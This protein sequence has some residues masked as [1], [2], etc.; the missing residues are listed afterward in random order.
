MPLSLGDKLGPYEIIDL[1]GKGGMGEVYRAHDDRLRR[2]VAIKVSNAHFTERFT[3]EART[4]AA[5]NHTNIAHL[6]D[7]GPNYLVMELVEGEDLKG[8][9]TFDD[10]LPIIQQLIDGIEAAHEKGIIHR[11]L[12]PANIKI[13]PEG[14]VK[15][16]DFGLAKA[17][18]TSQ[19]MEMDPGNSPTLTMGATAVGTILGTAAYM[20]PEQAK[21]KTADKRSDV[22]SFGVVV[23]E[24]LTGKHLFQGE[25][26]VE[27][28]GGVLNKEP[29]FSAAPA[30]LHRLLQWCLQKDRKKRLAAISDARGLLDEETAPVAV[31][32]AAGR[33]WLW[34]AVTAGLAVATGVALWAP[35]RSGSSAPQQQL[36]VTIHPAP[37]KPTDLTYLSPD[38]TRMLIRNGPTSAHEMLTLA[39]GELRTLPGTELARA[40][41]WS[42][43]SRF[44]AFFKDDKLKVIPAAGGPA[45][46]IC[47]GT[48]GGLGGSWSASGIVLLGS[49]AGPIRMVKMTNGVAGG[50]CTAVLPP[51][52]GTF[53]GYPRW[54][55]D[56]EHF[57]YT[58]RNFGD[59]S[60]QGV[61]LASLK[62]PA[63]RRILGD[64]T[65]VIYAPPAAGETAGQLLFRRGS[66]LM[67]QA[68]DLRTLATEGDPIELLPSVASTNNPAEMA[69]TISTNGAMAYST[70]VDEGQLTWL[71]RQGHKL[72][73][74][75]KRREASSPSL[76]PDATRVIVFDNFNGSRWL[77]NLTTGTETKLDDSRAASAQWSADGGWLVS[78]DPNGVLKLQ[79]FDGG[80]A[81]KLAEGK[82]A[83]YPSQW[84]ADNRWLF[85]TAEGDIWYLPNPGKPGAK[86]VMFVGGAGI[87]SQAQLSPDGNWLAYTSNESGSYQAYVCH[88]P[89][90]RDKQQ[91]SNGA[92]EPQ[93]SRDGKELFWFGGAGAQDLELMAAP[94][95]LGA[96]FSIGEPQKLF[97]FRSRQMLPFLNMYAYRPSPDGKRFLIALLGD[98]SEP[99]HH[100]VTDWRR[101]LKKQ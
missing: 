17:M 54:L 44:I 34:P 75:G 48:G 29:D 79:R 99:R 90:C 91:I 53:Q 1:L 69:V 94:V 8:P 35:W 21:G 37:G 13:T 27:I 16:L 51:E 36:N 80:P 77:L 76:S 95:Q 73:S 45:Q 14:V 20:A 50:D 18:D 9:M 33:Q 25:S 47:A 97:P 87:Q 86:P 59:R 78:W 58:A 98:D 83:M 74:I 19:S 24:M 84:T 4:V 2:D 82:G 12:K 65:S 89:D 100:L 88:F 64:D 32:Q 30:R 62:N 11:D 71:D 52:E 28:L 61:Y 72:Q 15:I 85:Y 38:G 70:R 43:D 101:L 3:R 92:S 7:V 6:Y 31:P 81:E 42:P 55:P 68:F 46:D 10:A 26:V 93:W 63:P 57:F 49:A 23:Y 96:S 60:T 22:W 41:F 40:P 5:L 66:A 39:T 56:G 67:A